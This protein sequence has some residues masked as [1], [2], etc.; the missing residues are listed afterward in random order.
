VPDMH[1]MESV[2]TSAETPISRQFRDFSQSDI[3]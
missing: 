3:V 2:W 1:T